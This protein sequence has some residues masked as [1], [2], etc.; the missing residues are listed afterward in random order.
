[1]MALRGRKEDVNM[2]VRRDD[3][4]PRPGRRQSKES[5]VMIRRKWE[6]K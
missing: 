1:M 3:T 6:G 2:T 4:D 5:G